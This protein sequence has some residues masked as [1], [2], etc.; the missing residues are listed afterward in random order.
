MQPM[1]ARMNSATTR[2]KQLD[3][4]LKKLT[5]GRAPGAF[6][7]FEAVR[8]RLGSKA[9]QLGRLIEV[10]PEAERWWPALELFL[11]EHRWTV[12]AP[13]GVDY[14][15]ALD[16]FRRVTPGRDGESLLNPA[17]AKRLRTKPLEDSLF[18]KVE[19]AHPLAR[20]Y[21]AHLLGD[22]KCVETPDELDACSAA[23]AITP[24]AMLKDAPARRRLKTGATVELTLG[25]EGLARMRAAKQSE[26][27]ETH[28]EAE[29][30][31]RQLADVNAWLEAGRNQGLGDSRLPDR[32]AE[33]P[34]LPALER[35]L[36]SLR[37]TIALLSTPERAARQE[38]LRDL[39]KRDAEARNAVA[40]LGERRRR[41]ETE[42]AAL[43]DSLAR[44]EEDA[45]S[46]QLNTEESRVALR[47]RFSG[48]LDGEIAARRDD[49]RRQHAKWPECF[50]ALADAMKSAGEI[51]VEAKQRRNSERLM[52]STARDSQGN[53]RHPEYQHDLSC[54]DESNEPWALRL[55]DLE[56]T[57][58]EESR[59]LA[60]DRRTEWER[61]LEDNVL[62]ELNRRIS[63]ATATVRLLERYLSQPVGKFRYRISQRKDTAGFGAIWALLN[64]GLEATDPLTAAIRDAEAKNA[65]EEL[66]R[67]LDAD[68]ADERGRRL[69]D[70]RNYHRY[71]IEVV[72]SDKPDAPPISLTRSGRNLSGGE[73]QAPFFISMLAAFRRVYDRGDRASSR[74]QQLGLVVM[75]EAF[76][77]LSGDGI[78]DCLALAKTFQLQ[79]VMAFPPERLGVMVPHAQTVVMCQ[80]NVQRDRE[81]YVTGITNVP[82]LATM[83][84]AL[85]ALE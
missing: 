32:S 35:E 42:T 65:K 52:L 50:G 55:R 7:L 2:V 44:A 64:S 85:E 11:G 58:L 73:S 27:N 76:S 45:R 47:R 8:Q 25:S 15:A 74:S 17:E 13:E 62:N 83:A 63:G 53:L 69:L 72:P 24:D 21:A 23:R 6:P 49:F 80:K 61:R 3:D 9:E 67:A 39:E 29:S 28:A 36:D 31:K 37:E 71:D 10:K 30:L 12:I 1:K 20:S 56:Q 54:E 78:E 4:D 43:R 70:Y 57:K 26:R 66:M 33:L 84:E 41:F 40:V 51:A 22:V 81:G 75:D 48:I 68:A 38:Q 46:E 82:M 77:K 5:E 60:A 59:L 18:S 19:I 79:L 14:M 34:Q 16:T